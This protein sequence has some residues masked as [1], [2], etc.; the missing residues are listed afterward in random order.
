LKSEDSIDSTISSFI[1]GKL[2]H[3]RSAECL[4]TAGADGDSRDF[5]VKR[6]CPEW[7]GAR[8]RDL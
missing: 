5:K 3:V 8:I 1:A 4:L 7:L 6:R 2:G